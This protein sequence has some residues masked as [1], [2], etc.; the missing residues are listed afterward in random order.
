MVQ[1]G[2]VLG[3]VISDRSIEVDMAKIEVIKRWPL[4]LL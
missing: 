1:E 3:H 4:L 2:A